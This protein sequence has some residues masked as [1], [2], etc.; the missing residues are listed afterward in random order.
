MTDI[1][2]LNEIGDL[3]FKTRNQVLVKAKVIMNSDRQ[4][5]YGEPENNFG[6]I[7]TY[8]NTYLKSKGY[9]AEDT[10]K[11]SDVSIMMG[12]LKTARTGSSPYHEDN[13][14]DA[15]NYFAIAYELAMIESAK[16]LG[17]K[18]LADA[19]PRLEKCSR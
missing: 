10:I 6:V 7:A 11:P 4:N 14:V 13:Y 19:E 17:R 16:E 8:W 15:V 1:N 2:D 18:M 3:K 12:L 9:I 5:N